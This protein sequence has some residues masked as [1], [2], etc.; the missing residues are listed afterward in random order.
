[1]NKTLSQGADDRAKAGRSVLRNLLFSMLA[2]GLAVG[3][4]SAICAYRPSD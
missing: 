1:M 2:F 4:I 3:L